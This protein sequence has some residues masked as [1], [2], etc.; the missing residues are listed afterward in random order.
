M[1][2]NNNFSAC[3]GSGLGLTVSFHV[4]TSVLIRVCLAWLDL[5]SDTHVVHIKSDPEVTQCD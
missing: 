4:M 1:S 2:K 5:S 3:V